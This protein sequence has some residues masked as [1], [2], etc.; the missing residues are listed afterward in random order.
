MTRHDLDQLHLLRIVLVRIEMFVD[1]RRRRRVDAPRG[2]MRNIE[3]LQPEGIQLPME[4]S[5]RRRN[6]EAMRIPGRAPLVAERIALQR[7]CVRHI[8]AITRPV[9]RIQPLEPRH[10]VR[11]R[12]DA[13]PLIRRRDRARR[14]RRIGRVGKDHATMAP[15]GLGRESHLRPFEAHEGDEVRVA[16]VS[17][18]RVALADALFRERVMLGTE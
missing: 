10:R 12:E 8:V 5:R 2:A 4:L 15:V 13:R 18:A 17:C 6:I 14:Q 11:R 16:R 7:L 9:Q 1:R 3:R